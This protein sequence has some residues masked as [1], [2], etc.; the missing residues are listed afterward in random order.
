MVVTQHL[1]TGRF[2]FL[3]GTLA[4]AVACVSGASDGGTNDGPECYSNADC[5]GGHECSKGV[6]VG[7]VGCLSDSNCRTNENCLD[8][9]CRLRCSAGDDCD[10]EGLIC[11]S[12]TQH[13]KPGQNPTRPQSQPQ[14]GS[15]GTGSTGAGGS[16]SHGGA[17]AT[18]GAAHG[19]SA[20]AA[21]SGGAPGIAGGTSAGLG[22][23]G[24]PPSGSAA[25]GMS[26][27]AGRAGL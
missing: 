24:G 16:A 15:G 11:G 17:P 14:S 1:R 25:A 4:W 22:V 3:I 6:C 27:A 18:G 8:S 7:Y 21:S 26:S 9:V 23:A 12:D 19:G 13:C 2:L 20:S 10:G 5:P